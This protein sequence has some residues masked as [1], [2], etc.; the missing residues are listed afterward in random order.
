MGPFT[1]MIRALWR[2]RRVIDEIQR[3]FLPAKLIVRFL[4][5][6]RAAALEAELTALQAKCEAAALDHHNQTFCAMMAAVE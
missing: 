1:G 2:R 3:E 4:C 5:G 6:P